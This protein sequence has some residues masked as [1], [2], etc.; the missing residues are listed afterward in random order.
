MERIHQL[1]C[2][3]GFLAAMTTGIAS[4]ATNAATSTIYLR[5]AVMMVAFFILGLYIKNTVLSLKKEMQIKKL[6]KEKAEAEE[7]RLHQQM[8]EQNTAYQKQNHIL[9]LVAGDTEDDFEPLAM[10]KAIRTKVK[11]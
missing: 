6:E 3:L 2:I 10:S 7:L 8:A 11:E 1:P 9:D 4:Y 5:M